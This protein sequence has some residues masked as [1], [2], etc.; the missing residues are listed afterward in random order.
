M[1]F[2]N[3]SDAIGHTPVVRLRLPAVP[4]V[5]VYAKLEL[6]NLFGMKDRVAR[7]I[8]LSAKR[9]GALM[10]GAPI[11]ESSSGTM[12]LGIALVGRALGHNVHIVTDP[13]ID[14]VTLAKLSSLGC[15]VHVV[16]AMTSHGWQSARLE[17]LEQLMTDLPGAFWP[18]QYSNPDNPGAYRALAQEI[19]ADLGQVDV[20]VGAVG[21]GGSLCGSARAL[22]EI[23]PELRV[24]GVDCV[25]SALFGQPDQPKRLQSGLGNS[26][27]PKN[28]DRRLIRE[29]HWLND[30][31]AFSAARAL[32]AE[33]QIFAGNTSG[34]VYRVLCELA[35][36]AEPG[37]R[38]V[39]I[40]P[41]RGDRY[42]DT[43]Y[44]DEYWKANDLSVMP[45]SHE[46]VEV[47]YGTVAT[48]WSRAVN[49]SA[50]NAEAYL[51]FVEANTSGTGMLALGIA[52]QMG[53][54]PILLTSE[55]S[56]Y[57]GLAEQ[58][59]EV[60]VCDTNSIRDLRE[61]IQERFRRDEIAGVTTTSDFYVPTVAELTDWLGLP[62][63]PVT[64]TATCR[65]KAALRQA[66]DE[67]GIGQPNF[68]V[69]ELHADDQD[70]ASAVETVGFPC[71]VKPVDD[72][73]SHNVLL[74]ES[75]SAVIE[76]VK[77]IRNSRTNAR[78]FAA[79]RSV[80]VEQ[81]LEHSEYSVE[82]F[83]HDGQ[84][85]CI[86]I[87]A[88]TV[89]GRPYFVELQHEFPAQLMPA[90]ARAIEE[91]VRAA[92]KAVG[93]TRG[94]T[95]TEIKLTPMGPMI[96]EINP[97]LA[98]GMIPELIRLARGTNLLEQQLRAA[99]GLRVD[100]DATKKLNSGICFLT[101]P[102]AGMLISI[103]HGTDLAAVEN[104]DT[105]K[106]TGRPGDSVRPPRDAYDRLGYVIAVSDN[107]RAVTS[108][109]SEAVARVD[110][111]VSRV[112][113]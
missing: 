18:K 94:A 4:D 3:I 49:N 33:Q 59:C 100:L 39:G 70:I 7:N 79:A 56:R 17:R 81:Y 12:A 110:I 15:Q 29:V 38:M 68:V 45:L 13:R 106:V 62:G 89:G 77:R 72:S 66:L 91:T 58:S 64:A 50:A 107:S 6:Q 34:S 86:G 53:M 24:V 19:L 98:G 16:K 102:H 88:K 22:R 23:W 27:L 54:Q 36:R 28:L 113:A 74:C 31:E 37:T 103:E 67:S 43:V 82:M 2:D 44:S 32:A 9:T 1:L 21:S 112:V 61:V 105:V 96:I 47:Y 63:N 51:L 104:I 76:H 40:F 57:S 80:L 92:L 60:I 99:V 83:G 42:A 87:T 69:L 71:V 101:A 111:R 95:H 73:G 78:G 65:N 30:H 97:R 52:G 35:T 25:G 55:P 5:E 11:V 14:P 10:E 85:I 109:L 84:Q 41:D 108:A 48:T 93:L 20:L 90:A 8:V 46:S 26:L 75:G